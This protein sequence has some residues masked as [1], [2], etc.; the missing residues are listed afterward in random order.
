MGSD[1]SPDLGSVAVHVGHS[2]KCSLKLYFCYFLKSHMFT[3]QNCEPNV[4]QTL[5]T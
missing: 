3:K 2:I 5:V 4:F 1:P